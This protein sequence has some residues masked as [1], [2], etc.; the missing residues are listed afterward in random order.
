MSPEIRYE[1]EYNMS[2]FY[3][4]AIDGPSGA[5]KSTLARKLAETFVFLYVDTGAISAPSSCP[6]RSSRSF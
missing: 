2:D 5:G 3:A 4:I 1:R 6:T